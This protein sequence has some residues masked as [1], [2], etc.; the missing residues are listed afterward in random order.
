MAS[1]RR[2]LLKATGC[3]DMEWVGETLQEKELQGGGQVDQTCHSKENR[4]SNRGPSL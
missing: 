3:L 1:S 2:G 4:G